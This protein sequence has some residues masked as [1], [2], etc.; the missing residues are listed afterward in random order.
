MRGPGRLGL[1]P[2]VAGCSR[3]VGIQQSKVLS[4]EL[5]FGAERVL[6]T[7]REQKDSGAVNVVE[8]C[9]AL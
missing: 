4:E 5:E 1:R 9:L 8:W 3:S 7:D 6:L 2:R